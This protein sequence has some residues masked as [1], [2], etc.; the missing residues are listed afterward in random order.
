[1]WSV[2][3]GPSNWRPRFEQVEHYTARCRADN[4]LSAEVQEAHEKSEN[5]PMQSKRPRNLLK[6]KFVNGTERPDQ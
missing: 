2:R 1:M 4:G 3:S 6:Y 5:N